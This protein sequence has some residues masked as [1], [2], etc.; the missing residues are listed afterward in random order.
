MRPIHLP[1][2]STDVF[3]HERPPSPTIAFSNPSRQSKPRGSTRARK[4]EQPAAAIVEAKPRLSLR[5]RHRPHLTPSHPS[6]LPYKGDSFPSVGRLTAIVLNAL[7]RDGALPGSVASRKRIARGDS[8]SNTELLLQRLLAELLVLA[9][10]EPTE[11]D[12]N[13]RTILVTRLISIA[14]R[15]L[16]AWNEAL[17][18]LTPDPYLTIPGLAHTCWSI[19]SKVGI[20]LRAHQ[21]C[22]GEDLL[23]IFLNP[24]PEQTFRA[25]VQDVLLSLRRAEGSNYSEEDFLQQTDWCSGVVSARTLKAWRSPQLKISRVRGQTLDDF[26]NMAAL[27]TAGTPHEAAVRTTSAKIRTARAMRVLEA[28]LREWLNRDGLGEELVLQLTALGVSRLR[29]AHAAASS[30]QCFEQFIQRMLLAS[31]PPEAA[32]GSWLGSPNAPHGLSP[33]MPYR[34]Y[35]R[36]NGFAYIHLLPPSAPEGTTGGEM[37]VA[38]TF[39]ET[40]L[41]CRRGEAHRDEVFKRVAG[42][43]LSY[44]LATPSVELLTGFSDDLSFH[45]AALPPT[46]LGVVLEVALWSHELTRNLSA[47]AHSI[48]QRVRDGFC[49]FLGPIRTPLSTGLKPSPNPDL[50]TGIRHGIVEASV[51]GP[52]SLLP[53]GVAEL[54]LHTF[55]H[56]HHEEQ[57]LMARAAS[58]RED[59]AQARELW[60]QLA[61][62]RPDDVFVRVEAFVARLRLVASVAVQTR[63]SLGAPAPDV[64]APNLETQLLHLQELTDEILNLSQSCQHLRV[65]APDLATPWI[66]S[67]LIPQLITEAMRQAQ[68]LCEF[69]LSG[70][71]LDRSRL[72]ARPGSWRDPANRASASERRP[73]ALATAYW[74][75]IARG[76]KPRGIRWAKEAAKAGGADPDLPLL[77]VSP[78]AGDLLNLA[79]QRIDDVAHDSPRRTH[80]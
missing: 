68:A 28:K 11:G 25:G 12:A 2:D 53:V 41:T 44:P 30:P 29:E 56:G 16:A 39:F 37:A 49:A 19:S 36:E 67:V 63:A 10:P 1:A 13:T 57:L 31:V 14:A 6:Y 35:L 61:A 80:E 71:D 72:P 40:F 43:W 54:A 51:K 7:A 20:L 64:C 9:L 26:L 73:R 33:L 38:Q 52:I 79:L 65:G 46:H 76:E 69:L 70:T 78:N 48:P 32:R 18:G 55:A 50:V 22:T 77:W 45:P 15:E 24:S 59:Y 5:R 62:T 17:S 75:W 42:I 34:R 8:A 4:F 21:I 23:T 74:V 3:N 27:R 58:D 47:P 60:L 66:E